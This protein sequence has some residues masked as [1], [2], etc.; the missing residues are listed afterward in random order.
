[1]NPLFL[2]DFYKAGHHRQY[3]SDVTKV[4]SNWTP[5][6]TRL[7][8]SDGVIWFGLQ[9]FIKKVLQEDFGRFFLDSRRAILKEYGAILQNALGLEPQLAHI[10]ALHNSR[11]A[12]WSGAGHLQGPHHGQL[13]QEVS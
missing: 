2:I 6:S 8:N 7:A 1:M 11:G 13:S 5:R 3:P 12:R 4:W 10:E 9:H